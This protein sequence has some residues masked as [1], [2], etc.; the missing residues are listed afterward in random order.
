MKSLARHWYQLGKVMRTHQTFVVLVVV[1]LVLL[2]VFIRINE[3]GSMPLDQ[4]YL[5]QEGE[6]I[7]SVK[8]NEEAIEQIKALNESN[9]NDPGTRLPT[10]RQ[11]PF[12]E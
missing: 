11:N 2:A 9:V 3:L 6:K 10:D 4:A 8:F 12:S 7:K 1:L 5:Q